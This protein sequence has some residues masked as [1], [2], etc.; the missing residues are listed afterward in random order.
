MITKLIDLIFPIKTAY[1]HCDIPCGIY[2]PHNAQVAAHT[3]IRMT[4]MINDLKFDSEDED[5]IKKSHHQ[6]A[7]L[8]KVKEEHA[9]LLKHEVRVI[10]GDYFKPEIVEKFP[11]LH[12]Q[13]WKIMR[14]A[15][16]A[17]QEVNLAAADELLEAVQKF[18]ETYYQSKGLEP[19]RVKS[20][21]PTEGEI[22]VHK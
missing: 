3:I 11:D 2:D 10:W 16:K 19:V 18:A 6:I 21:F 20:G 5:E 9:E 13:V 17:R 4:T 22:V 14:L 7:R 1:A 12:D 15:S 8:V